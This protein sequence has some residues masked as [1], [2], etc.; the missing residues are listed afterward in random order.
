M[1]LGLDPQSTAALVPGSIPVKPGMTSFSGAWPVLFSDRPG[2][3]S[4]QAK[5]Q[6]INRSD[7][8]MSALDTQASAWCRSSSRQSGRGERS[9]DIFSRLLRERMCSWSGR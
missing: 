1:W 9:Y 3:N 5:V 6:P 7:F 2:P 4:I 8:P